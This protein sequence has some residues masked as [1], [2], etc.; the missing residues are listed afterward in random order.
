MPTKN[1]PNPIPDKNYLRSIFDYDPDGYL[2]WKKNGKIAG[3][4][5]WSRS[6]QY[7]RLKLDQ[8]TYAVSRLIYCWHFDNIPDGYEVDHIDGDGLNNKINNLRIL[9]VKQNRQRRSG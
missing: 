7:Y 8:Y 6:K 3:S 4:I 2:I 5:I 9:T 1:T